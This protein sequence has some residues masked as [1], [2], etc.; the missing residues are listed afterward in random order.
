MMEIESQDIS[1]DGI[2]FS[3]VGSEED[4][5]NIRQGIKLSNN[6]DDAVTNLFKDYIR[7][8]YNQNNEK[9]YSVDFIDSDSASYSVKNSLET[10]IRYDLTIDAD[11]ENF[12]S[13][14]KTLAHR[15]IS[16][17]KSS[18]NPKPGI[19]FVLKAKIKNEKYIFI[20]KVDLAKEVIQIWIDEEHLH[21]NVDSVKNAMPAPDKLQKGAI[22]PHPTLGKDL[23]VLQET[24]LASYFDQFLQCK[25][26]LTE[27]NQFKQVPKILSTISN[28]LGMDDEIIC[29]EADTEVIL[30]DCFSESDQ[31][32]LFTI[33]NLMDCAKKV[34]PDAN[35]EAIEE[36][37]N[38]EL[39][40]KKI[41]DIYIES[42]A[43]LKYR[44][45]ITID[46]IKIRGPFKSIVE[47]VEINEGDGNTYSLIVRGT[48]KPRT[49]TI[50]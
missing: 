5:E 6:S 25:R 13:L 27:F 39:D 9:I 50:K 19:L 16:Q 49:R 29:T 40:T 20:L 48:T 21:L 4:L 17:M 33:E 12:K 32:S 43:T 26:E 22:Y 36:I 47:K 35:E 45:E 11:V 38:R 10:S 34:V 23:K 18:T 8:I 15:L 24:H 28:E 2:S 3:P 31:E 37:V 14:A 7:Y 42:N 30:T 41:E 44:K 1:I 46:D